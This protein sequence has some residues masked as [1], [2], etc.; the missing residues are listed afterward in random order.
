MTNERSDQ[1][2]KKK[3]VRRIIKIVQKE[4]RACV[5][6][7]DNLLENKANGIQ[8]DPIDLNVCGVIAPVDSESYY[9]SEIIAFDREIKELREEFNLIY[10]PPKTCCGCRFQSIT[11]ECK[12]DCKHYNKWEAYN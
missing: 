4:K 12:Q 5:D 9:K 8:A 10:K 2:D 1:L 11:D 3:E 6:A 7:Y